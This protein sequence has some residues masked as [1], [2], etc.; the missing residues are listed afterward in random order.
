[1]RPSPLV[2]AVLDALPA[3]QLALLREHLPL[4]D[5]RE[6]RFDR[7]SLAS[8]RWILTRAE[9]VDTAVL[10]AATDL[11]GVIG[12]GADTGTIDE[13]ACA[14]RGV[15]VYSITSPALATVAEHTVMLILMLLKRYQEA[16]RRLRSGLVAGNVQPALTT[17]QAYAYNWVGLERFEGL[18]GQTIGLVGL[19]VI[20]SRTARLLRAFD[21]DVAYTKPARLPAEQEL[22]VGVRFLALPDLLAQ[23]RCVSL[24]NRF[25]EETDQMMGEREFALMRPGSFFVNTARGRLVDE[26]A[27]G[28][29]LESGHLAG[30]ALDVF[31]YEPLPKDSPLLRA[32]NLILTPHVGGIPLAESQLLEVREAARVIEKEA[33]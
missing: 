18:A 22:N 20:G 24:H 16:S 1:M 17:Q 7:T 27:L 25:T 26:E 14:G 4:A 11:D 28:A 6:A 33:A 31:R 13:L 30:A 10:N 32:P 29:A 21:A 12:L 15:K 19:G 8:A 23:S 2:V 3:Q 5:V 9:P